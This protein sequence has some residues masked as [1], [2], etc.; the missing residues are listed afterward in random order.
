MKSE[1]TF[2]DWQ[3]IELKIGEVKEVGNKIKIQCKEKEYLTEVK[4][5][6]KEGDKIVVGIFNDEL[7]MP[8]IEGDNPLVSEKDA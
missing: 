1:I 8:L 3:K 6:V 7:V 2:E 5:N 4:I